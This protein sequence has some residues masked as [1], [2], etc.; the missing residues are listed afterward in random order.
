[1]KDFFRTV[2][3]YLGYIVH[4]NKDSKVIYYHDI[5]TEYTEMGTDWSLFRDH[6]GILKKE[7]YNIVDKIRKKEGEIQICFDDGWEGLYQYKE[8]IVRMGVIPTV[9][10]AVDLIGS[11]GH[12][13]LKQIKEM[14]EMGY[15]FQGHTWSHNDLTTM[16][17]KDIVHEI[18]DSKAELSRLLDS[19]VDELCFPCGRFSDKIVEIARTA[20]YSKLY[21]SLNGSFLTITKDGLICRQLCQSLSRK[22]FRFSVCGFSNY[23]FKRALRHHKIK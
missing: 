21:T 11:D 15:R 6:I 4:H 14:Q 18:V 13:T 1:M 5:S 19:N 16:D 20:H 10:V 8:E 9:F 17:E 12:L 3:L 7:G 2:I 23:L 22:Q